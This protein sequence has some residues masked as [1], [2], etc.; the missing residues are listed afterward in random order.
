MLTKEIQKMKI[1]GEEIYGIYQPDIPYVN[2]DGVKRTLQVIIPETAQDSDKKYPA[3]LHVQG[4][5]WKKQ[6]VYKRVGVN[7]H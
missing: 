2:R 3:I 4:S 7:Q 1:T 5:A 6:D